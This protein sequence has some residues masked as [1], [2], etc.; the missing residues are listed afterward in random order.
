MP[1][2]VGV[3]VWLLLLQGVQFHP[4]SIITENGM[5]IVANFVKTL[6]LPAAV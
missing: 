4:E 3:I 1:A 5:T 6:S 2:C